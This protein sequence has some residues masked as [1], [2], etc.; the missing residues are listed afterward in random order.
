MRDFGTLVYSYCARMVSDEALAADVHQQVFEQ[1]FRDLATL[2]DHTRA[3]S[4]LFGIAHHRCLDAIKAR[5][6]FAKRFTDD[7]G[8]LPEPAFD[9]P[10]AWER[11]DG[12]RIARALEACVGTLTPE[13]R[14][15]LL[16]RYQEGMS[17]EKMSSICRE[18]AG[19]L[20]AR[21]ARALPALKR[22]L[23]TKGVAP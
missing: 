21:V 5:R 20:Q 6:R 2:E 12:K 18:K 10:E 19:T 4:W 22:C 23:Q 9:S 11:V 15:A 7:D 16:L 8:S 17:F 3:R 1:A 14:T 13:S